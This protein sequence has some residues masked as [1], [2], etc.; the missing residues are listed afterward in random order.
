MLLLTR[1][2]RTLLAETLRDVA[3]VAVGA[4]VFGQFLA[5]RMFS[6]WVAVLGVAGWL[7]LVACALVI[8]RGS[9]P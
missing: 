1:Q 2:Q 4:M 5:D 6:S 3:N 9:V 7:I 8:A